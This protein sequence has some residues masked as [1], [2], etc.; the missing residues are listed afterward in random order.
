LGGNSLSDLLVFGK[1]AGEYA[2]R[3]A[4]GLPT[5]PRIGEAEIATSAAAAEEPFGRP[6]NEDNAFRVQRELQQMMHEHVGIVRNETEMAA[7][8]PLL[9]TMRDR[10][11][12]VSVEGNRDY[13]PGWHTAL[14]LPNL[15]TISE[16]ITRAALSRKESR[17]GHFRED[18]PDKD[19]SAAK[20]NTVIRKA[21]DG[22]MVVEK[23]PCVPLSDE[24][25][26]LID[27]LG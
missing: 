16:A 24:H 17:G 22:S 2:A 18:F 26:A 14:D 3:Y 25:K 5:Q 12:R 13:N 4:Q 1:R 19:A 27:E 6:D 9:E 21:A 11:R 23:R 20:E 7:A 8:L 10:A 15:L